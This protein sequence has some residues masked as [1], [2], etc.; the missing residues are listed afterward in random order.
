M[1]FTDFQM[2]MTATRKHWRI[3]NN[4]HWNLDVVFAEDKC[5][6]K[7]GYAASNLN[8]F[9][10]TCLCILERARKVMTKAMSKVDMLR[11]CL[12]YPKHI[13]N[14]LQGVSFA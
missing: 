10:K 8:V 5:R 14:M 4:L 1:S 12:A 11:R 2:Y 6:A 3:E 7:K 9:R 13:E